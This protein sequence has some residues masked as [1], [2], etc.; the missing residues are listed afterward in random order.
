VGALVVGAAVVGGVV[1]AA[2]EAVV[3]VPIQKVKM[4]SRCHAI[5]T[6]NE[7][8]SVCSSR[9]SNSNIATS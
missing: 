2:G 7:C 9:D 3:L 6:C 4:A 1:V 8:D 5:G